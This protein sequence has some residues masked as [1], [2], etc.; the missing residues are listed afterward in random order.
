MTGAATQHQNQPRGRF[1]TLEGGEGVGKS[2]QIKRL[3]S[4]LEDKGLSIVVTREPGGSK[5]A[6]E[7]RN[8]LVTGEPGRWDGAS[9]A[10]L[11]FAARQNHVETL[12]KPALAN[13][14]WV[15]CDRFADSTMAYQGYGHGWGSEKVNQL[16]RLTLGNFKPDLTLLLDMPVEEGLAR[17][18]LRTQIHA[19][20]QQGSET[21]YESMSMGFHE[22][23]RKG[24]LRIAEREPGR[25]VVIDARQSVDQV[26]A[27]INRTVQARLNIELVDKVQTGDPI[28]EGLVGDTRQEG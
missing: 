26:G 2:T 17:A 8:L 7:I 19:L 14:Q 12:I 5:G 21:R 9:E 15:I 27:A 23:L 28:T 4:A 22:K 13:G 10:L 3:A 18:E 24:F 20:A 11:N 1:I 6:E 25:C 16:Y